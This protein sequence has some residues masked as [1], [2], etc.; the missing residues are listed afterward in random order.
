MKTEET[1]LF[2][3]LPVPWVNGMILLMACTW[4]SL[5]KSIRKMR[6]NAPMVNSQH[7]SDKNYLIG[8]IVFGIGKYD[9]TLIRTNAS[10]LFA[11]DSS[12]C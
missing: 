1:I 4:A 3:L 6:K 9:D 12:W 10:I 11:I 2:M 5:P 7:H 8:N